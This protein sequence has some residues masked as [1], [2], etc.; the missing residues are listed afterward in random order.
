VDVLASQP[1]RDEISKEPFS[2]INWWPSR[3]AHTTLLLLPTGVLACLLWYFLRVSRRR[4]V[5]P[6]RRQ[7]RRRPLHL[8]ARQFLVALFAALTFKWRVR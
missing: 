2:T 7:V 4:R 8:H 5:P 6:S 1:E 3:K